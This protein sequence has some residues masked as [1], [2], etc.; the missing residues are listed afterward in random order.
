MIVSTSDAR[1]NSNEFRA[2]CEGGV[3]VLHN[4]RAFSGTETLLISTDRD[5]GLC[6]ADDRSWLQDTR[7]LDQHVAAT[8]A[9]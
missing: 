6:E 5:T 4:T 8:F 9:D 2:E 7:Q 3:I 1:A